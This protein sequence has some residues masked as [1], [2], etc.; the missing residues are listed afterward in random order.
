MPS[1]IAINDHDLHCST[2]DLE[3]YFL[4]VLT[5]LT[6]SNEDPL[7]FLFAPKRQG[8]GSSLEA[9]SPVK[10]DAIGEVRM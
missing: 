3:G 9:V 2:A 7:P 1:D 10:T 8:R 5:G 6:A 4:Y